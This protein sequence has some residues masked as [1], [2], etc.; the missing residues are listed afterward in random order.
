MHARQVFA[1][2]AQGEQLDPGKNDDDGGQEGEAGYNAA[3]DQIAPQ[4]V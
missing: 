1:E 2:N 3:E 4:Q